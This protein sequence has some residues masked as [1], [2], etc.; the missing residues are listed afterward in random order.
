MGRI[1]LPLCKN[2]GRDHCGRRSVVT[3]RLH[4]Q[5][6]ILEQRLTVSTLIE[7]VGVDV[8]PTIGNHITQAKI[9]ASHRR[10]MTLVEGCDVMTTEALCN[11]HPR[12][13]VIK[14]DT[15]E[16]LARQGLP[17]VEA[18]MNVRGYSIRVVP[19]LNYDLRNCYRSKRLLIL[20]R[21][22]NDVSHLAGAEYVVFGNVERID[23]CR[24]CTKGT[25]AVSP[26]QRSGV[27]MRQ[28]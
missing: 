18:L 13:V 1:V 16:A 24:Q 3:Q 19:V 23:K 20:M 17:A 27:F 5:S 6:I 8:K 14:Q 26:L 2:V 15:L 21:L 7:L 12:F 10:V 9:I 25:R 4:L 28:G 22:L 11:E